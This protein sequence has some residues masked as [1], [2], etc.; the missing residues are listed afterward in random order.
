MLTGSF[1]PLSPGTN[2]N[3]TALGPVDWIDW[4]QFTEFAYDRKFIPANLISDFTVVGNPTPAQGPFRINSL[5]GGYSWQ[6]GLQNSFATNTTT[7]DYMLGKDNGFSIT[8]PIGTTTNIL[9]IYV[10]SLA[11]GGN[12]TATLSDGGAGPFSS[13]SANVVEGCYTLTNAGATAGAT[14]TVTWT[15]SANNS[16]I[17]LQSAALAYLTANNPPSA[18]LTIPELNANISVSSTQTVQAVATDSDGAVSL[19]QFFAETN[20]IG[21]TT[22]SPY[23][24]DW[25]NATPGRHSLTVKVTDNL[26]ATYTSKPLDVFVYTNGGSLA[27]GGAVPPAA[28][29]LSDEGTNDWAH[30][31]LTSATDFD[32]KAGVPQQISNFTTVGTNAALQYGD[33]LTAYSWTGGTPAASASLSTTGIYI[34]GLTN[35]FQL[36]V[37][38]G[39]QSRTVKVY[40]GLYGARSDFRAWLS[41][42]SAPEFS[43]TTLTSNYDNAYQVYTLNYQ[44]AS[45]NQTLTVRHTALNSYD[46]VFGNVTLQAATLS[47]GPMPLSPIIL[48]TNA[49]SASNFFSFSFGTDPG[50]AYEVLYADSLSTTNWQ[51]LTNFTGD[52]TVWSITDTNTAP[53][54]FYRVLRP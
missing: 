15:G 40:V 20:E 7:G 38:A 26:G 10:A 41:D 36:T 46:T 48:L 14:L 13:S 42:A 31:G 25:T 47:L 54:R 30:W 49:V 44:A 11:G 16:D 2:I 19:A 8:V 17:V 1:T 22:A 53:S 24:I 21:E 35:G 29:I 28:V 4:G 34:Y 52:G 18:T 50:A 27:G 5:S 6:D 3:L 51:L 37:P 23:S 45:D 33:N 9:R 39:R 12:F 43:D 32:H